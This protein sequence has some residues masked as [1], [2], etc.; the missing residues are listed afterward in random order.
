MKKIILIVGLS[1]LATIFL[2]TVTSGDRPL[3]VSGCCKE[4]SSYNVK[5]FKNKM[6]FAKCKKQNRKDGDDVFEKSG[7]IWWDMK[8]R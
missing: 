3:A 1:L 7:L 5:W 4:R 6:P 8:C 2:L